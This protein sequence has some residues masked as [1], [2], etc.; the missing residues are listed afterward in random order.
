[1]IAPPRALLERHLVLFVVLARRG[2]GGAGRRRAAERR[3]RQP[4]GHRRRPAEGAAAGDQRLRQ[5]LGVH[6]IEASTT[7]SAPAGRAAIST[8]SGG[9]CCERARRV[10]RAPSWSTPAASAP[11]TQADWGRLEEHRSRRVEKRS[12]RALA[13][14]DLLALP[15]LYRAA[16]SSLSVARETSLDRSADHLSRG[17]VRA[18]LF[19]RLRRPDL[20][21]APDRP[22][23]RARLAARRC[24]PVARDPGLRRCSR[25]L[26][27]VARLSA[28]RAATR[29]GS[30]ASSRRTLAGGRDPSAIGAVPARP[31][32]RP[33]RARAGWR[34][35]PPSCS[36]T[37][38]RSRCFAFALGFAFGVPTALLLVYNG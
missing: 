37:T 24:R 6:V 11:R 22:L 12:V 26:G 15:V 28:R 20:G 27:A 32:L 16:L 3:R 9:T 8:S 23:L 21:L 17:A 31:A 35:S 1:M 38:R 14:E 30:T 13:D 7:G 4:R 18:R 33:A 36:P 2:A 10:A 29:A 34:A 25:L 5:H 19:L